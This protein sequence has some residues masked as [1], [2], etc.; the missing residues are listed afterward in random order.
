MTKYNELINN[1][2]YLKLD[3]M[4]GSLSSYLDLIK[5]GKKSVIDALYEMSEK[6]KDM[7]KKRAISACVN[8][9]GFPFIKTIDDFDFSFQ[10]GIS[11]EEIM[12]YCSLRFIEEKENLLFIGSSGTGKTH[13]AT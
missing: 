8:T 3:A 13:L 9:A 5:D 1:L 12:D 7:R 6:E 4:R 11:K 10:P 2:E